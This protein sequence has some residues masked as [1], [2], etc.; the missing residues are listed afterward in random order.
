MKLQQAVEQPNRIPVK[1]AP[2]RQQQR[3]KARMPN[4][5]NGKITEKVDINI[6]GK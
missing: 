4:G 1:K 2:I 5:G 6:Y 3:T